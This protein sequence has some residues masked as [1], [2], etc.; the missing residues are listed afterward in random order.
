MTVIVEFIAQPATDEIMK[1]QTCTT[2]PEEYDDVRDM[3]SNFTKYE[4]LYVILCHLCTQ[5][6]F[7]IILFIV[8]NFLIAGLMSLYALVFIIG[9]RVKYLRLEAEKAKMELARPQTPME[10]IVIS[11]I[12]SEK[13]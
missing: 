10:D 9:V 13:K 12:T 8:P 1:T 3:T 6:T 7:K 2:D 5:L 4:R 11:A